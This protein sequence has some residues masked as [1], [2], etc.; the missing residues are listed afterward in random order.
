MSKRIVCVLLAVVIALMLQAPALAAPADE[1]AA[2]TAFDWTVAT[3]E[4]E[5][6]DTEFDV[7]LLSSGW[8]AVTYKVVGRNSLGWALYA[9]YHR[10]EWEWDSTRITVV[11]RSSW[12]EV[13]APGWEYMGLINNDGYYYNNNASYYSF[14]QAHF[15]LGSGGWDVQHAYPWIRYRVHRG[16][17]YSVSGG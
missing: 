17:S 5:I 7:G 2:D 10:I 15:R 4:L 13:Y 11:R 16:G 12:P 3:T 9:F 6:V 1:L 8:R 14:R